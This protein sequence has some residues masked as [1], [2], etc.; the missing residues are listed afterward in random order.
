LNILPLHLCSYRRL[1]WEGARGIMRAMKAWMRRIFRHGWRLTVAACGW[2]VACPG[3]FLE[4]AYRITKW[5]TDDGLPENSATAMVQAPD[6]YLWFGTFNGLV[7]FDG[8]Q[9]DVFNPSNT[10]ELPGRALSTF[11]CTSPDGCGSAPAAAWPASKEAGG[12]NT[13]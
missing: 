12:N 1:H 7:R 4:Q 2:A 10:P 5:E 6:G 11:I 9:F 13:G 3:G 8:V